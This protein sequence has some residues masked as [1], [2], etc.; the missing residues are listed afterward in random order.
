[1]KTSPPLSL[2]IDPGAKP[3]L[4]K[5]CYQVPVHFKEKVL[6]SLE[7]DVKLGVWERV[8][9]NTKDIWCSPMIITPK[10]NGEP[11]R[12]VDLRHLNKSAAR[13]THGGETPFSLA[14]SV[15]PGTYWTTCDAWNGYHSVPIREEDRHYTTFLT[16]WGRYRYRTVPQGFLSSGDGYCHRFDEVTRGFQDHKRLVDD[17]ILWDL[18][19]E[20]LFFK[21]CRYLTMCG[22]GGILMNRNK[23][24]FGKKEV[25]Y[26][27][28]QLTEVGVEPGDELM[29]SIL[30]FPRP[31]NISGIR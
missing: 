3:V 23:F 9:L 4:N 10:K 18:S 15:P 22:N 31:E 2:M 7:T 28:F 24:V 13:Q 26:L 29:K 8:P 19:L 12:I 14:T 21:T 30:N 25:E 11:R 1:M 27:G 16:E 5:K 17:S 6:K 20:E